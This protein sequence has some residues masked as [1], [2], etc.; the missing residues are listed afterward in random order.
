MFA[1]WL[2]SS[3]CAVAGPEGTAALGTPTTT[4]Q[5]WPELVSPYHDVRK[6]AS[7]RLDAMPRPDAFRAV[8]ALLRSPEVGAR[9]AGADR[10]RTL[11][12]DAEQTR[13]DEV[14]LAVD[15]LC[16]ETHATVVE[17]LVAAVAAH[18]DGVAT[19]R[20]RAN[21]TA[22]YADRFRR[23]LDARIV[24]ALEARLHFGRIPGFYDGQ[25][26]EVFALDPTAYERVVRLA[27]DPRLNYVLR[28]MAIVALHEPRRPDLLGVLAPLLIRP[29]HEIEIQE[30]IPRDRTY[31][32]S[33]E[34][35]L[36]R[37][38]L[39]QYTR[40][41]LAKAGIAE[42]IDQKITLL[43]QRARALAEEVASIEGR[44]EAL[45]ALGAR[46][47]DMALLLDWRLGETMDAYFELGYHHQQLDRYAQAERAYRTITERPEQLTAKRWAYYNLAC[48]RSIQGD[49]DGAIEALA[50]AVDAGFSDL[51]WA[52]KDGDLAPLRDDPRFARLIAGRR[53]A[54][55]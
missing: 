22:E 43:E 27:W 5:D 35:L 39:S 48:I 33:R 25:F 40:F 12:A 32:E 44:L 8:A 19:L 38:N 52:A 9:S 15:A 16:T 51:A 17:R 18:A 26:A 41:A 11:L 7:A 23:V 37:A 30:T 49:R 42:P 4:A 55:K 3:V 46:G 34:M 47:N 36:I 29:D 31:E 2:I 50:E 13:A 21:A 28:S 20:T 45:G 24:V 14:A 1:A 6:A 53:A 54:A 10:L